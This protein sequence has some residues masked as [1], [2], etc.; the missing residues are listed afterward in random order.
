MQPEDYVHRIGRTG[1]AE[2]VGQSYTLVT[3]LDAPIIQR[4]E[5]VLKQQLK[6][7]KVAGLDYN[8]PPALTHRHHLS[9][10]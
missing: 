4:I 1:R 10:R 7:S 6:R 3:P 5:K 2:A 8:A 9:P